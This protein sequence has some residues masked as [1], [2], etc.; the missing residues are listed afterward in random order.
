MVVAG[1]LEAEKIVSQTATLIDAP[2]S[3]I[4]GLNTKKVKLCESILE[5]VEGP[6]RINRIGL[7]PY[8]RKETSMRC[9][10]VEPQTLQKLPK[11]AYPRKPLPSVK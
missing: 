6:T 7:S 5:D 10:A 1:N 4:S 11:L 9:L 2:K 3:I 8:Y